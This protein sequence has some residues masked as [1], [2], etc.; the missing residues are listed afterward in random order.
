MAPHGYD[1]G[2]SIYLAG[3]KGGLLGLFD[4]QPRN[5]GESARLADEKL[6]ELDHSDDIGPST[7]QIEAVSRGRRGHHRLS[8]AAGAGQNTLWTAPSSHP[9]GCAYQRFAHT[10]ESCG[11]G[12]GLPLH[13]L[14]ADQQPVLELG[15]DGA[16]EG[17]DP[18]TQNPELSDHDGPESSSEVGLYFA[19]TVIQG[20]WWTSLP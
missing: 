8:R 16:V 11:A 4:C 3:L 17:V 1:A 6:S 20:Q 18:G 15:S 5:Q 2:R 14:P 13:H 19:T 9:P 10:T 12:V 7:T